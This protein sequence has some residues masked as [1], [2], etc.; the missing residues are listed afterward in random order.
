MTQDLE[1]IHANILDIMTRVIDS[2]WCEAI[3]DIELHSFAMKISGGY[4]QTLE[5]E[6]LSFKFIKED[7]KALVNALL[8][9]HLLSSTDETNHWNTLNYHLQA[10]GKY[11]MQSSWNQVLEDDIERV[12]SAS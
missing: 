6:P 11:K 12:R 10:D 7:K 2:A 3:L 9:L 5:G 1:K 4:K 8:E